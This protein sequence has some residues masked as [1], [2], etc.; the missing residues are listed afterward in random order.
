MPDRLQARLDCGQHELSKVRM[1]MKEQ[2]EPA[3]HISR[4]HALD[5]YMKLY[6]LMHA[7]YLTLQSEKIK[8]SELTKLLQELQGEVLK[9]EADL[10][11]MK[12]VKYFYKN[13]KFKR[14]NG[15]RRV[16]FDNHMSIRAKLTE[17]IRDDL[18]NAAWPRKCKPPIIGK[19]WKLTYEELYKEFSK[20]NAEDAE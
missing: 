15:D 4:I 17:F 11:Q 7:S 14:L 16:S 10:I 6:D 13:L 8:K 18:K 2:K 19:N 3:E 20:L 9:K 5:F 1:T 12:Y